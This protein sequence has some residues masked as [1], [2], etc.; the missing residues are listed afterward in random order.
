MKVIAI[1]GSPRLKGNT[2]YLIDQVLEELNNRGLETEKFILSQYKIGPCQ[3]HDNCGS[4]TECLQKDDAQII[5]EKFAQADGIVLASPVYYYSISAQM[6]I[7]IDRNYFLYTH[8][9]KLKARCAG[10]IAIGGGGG[11]DLAIGELK[12]LVSFTETPT[13]V[14]SGYAGPPGAVK[15]K[16]DIINLVRNIGIRMAETLLKPSSN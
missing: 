12:K 6:K 4:L 1:G 7:F 14:V 16:K 2:N 13:L 8:N 11:A 10:L 9:T 3:A 15:E 5:L